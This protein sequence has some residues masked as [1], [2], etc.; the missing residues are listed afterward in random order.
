MRVVNEELVM[1]Y[2]A[3]IC[4]NDLSILVDCSQEFAQVFFW[5]FLL[6]KDLTRDACKFGMIF[7]DEDDNKP[8]CNN[9]LS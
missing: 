1:V 6:K 4:R 2:K 5:N 8:D 3:S 9:M 7:L